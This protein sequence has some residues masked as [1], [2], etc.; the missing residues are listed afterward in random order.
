MP[1][2]ESK[3]KPASY[4]SQCPTPRG[5]LLAIGGS[6]SKEGTPKADS[7]QENNH[8]FEAYEILQRFGKELRGDDPLIVVFPTASSIPEEMGQTYQ[9]V[10]GKLGISRVEILDIRTRQDAQHRR[11][12]EIVESGAGF[13]FTGGDQLRLTSMLGGTRL[14]E[15]LKER[16]TDDEIIIAGTSAGAAALSTP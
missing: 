14:M 13:M 15:R 11:C 12:L 16:Y 1:K 5:K 4:R 3:P 2:P 9:E 7:N 8:N 10:F 6:E